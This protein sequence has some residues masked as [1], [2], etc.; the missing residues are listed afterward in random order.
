MMRKID[1]ICVYDNEVRRKTAYH[2]KALNHFLCSE[3]YIKPE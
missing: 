1:Q 3:T 2:E